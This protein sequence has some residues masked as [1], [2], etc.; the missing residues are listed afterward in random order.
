M[1]RTASKLARRILKPVVYYARNPRALFE[2]ETVAVAHG[3]KF[4]CKRENLI[5]KCILETG[6]WESGETALVKEYVRSGTVAVDVGANIGYF[7]LLMSS[8]AGPT[9][10]VHAFEPTRYAFGRLQ[11]NR[12]L[13][14]ALPA[15]MTLNRVGLLSEP[16]ART[17]S[18]EARSAQRSPRTPRKNI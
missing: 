9:G 16:I 10:Q 15:N 7:T 12:A 8:L 4:L 18:L 5:E 17:E 14:P 3:L 1:L 11:Q 2:S 13:N 6:T